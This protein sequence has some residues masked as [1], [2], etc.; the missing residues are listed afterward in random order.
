M[1]Q[2][3]RDRGRRVVRSV[4]PT[5]MKSLEDV[6][7][8][9]DEVADLRQQVTRQRR[10]IEELEQEVTEARR[11]NRRIAE[12]TDVVQE[13]LVPVADRDDERLRERLDGYADTL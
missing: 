10:R 1:K 7:R 13:L 11:L 12:L 9:T 2:Q 5:L 3:V 6:A 4:A 8:L